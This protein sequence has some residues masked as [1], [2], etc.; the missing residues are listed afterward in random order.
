MI[1]LSFPLPGMVYGQMIGTLRTQAD[2]VAA[3]NH[4]IRSIV[5]V[6]VILFFLAQFVNYFA[7]S[8]MDRMLAYAGGSL[9][10]DAALPIP[11]LFVLVVVLAVRQRYRPADLG[12]GAV[13]ARARRHVDRAAGRVVLHGPAARPD[14]PADLHAGWL[15]PSAAGNPAAY[16]A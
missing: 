16:A 14:G 9:L 8:Q 3:V 10:F 12:H 13:L 7:Y 6:L 5:P 11:L 4:G 2:F 15:T 1:L